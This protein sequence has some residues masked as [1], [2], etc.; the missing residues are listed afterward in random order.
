MALYLCY[1]FHIFDRPVLKKYV[2]KVN[3]G[4]HL[5]QSCLCVA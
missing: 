1:K 5:F 4:P 3:G 2:F